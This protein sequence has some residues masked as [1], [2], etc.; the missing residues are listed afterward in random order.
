MCIVASSKLSCGTVA[1]MNES[2][3]GEASELLFTIVDSGS[4]KIWKVFSSGETEGFSDGCMVIN[5]LDG[6]VL[7]EVSKKLKQ[8]MDIGFLQESN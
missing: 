7:S 2:A 1:L 8:Q 4:D 6:I 3:K 5:H